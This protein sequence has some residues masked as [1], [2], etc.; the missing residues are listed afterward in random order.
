MAQLRPIFPRAF[1]RAIPTFVPFDESNKKSFR[2]MKSISTALILIVI[3]TSCAYNDVDPNCTTRATVRDLT[4]FDGCGYVFE[5]ED[6]TRLEPLRM[7][8]CGTHPLPKEITEDPLY[9]FEFVHGKKVRISYELAK[10]GVSICMVGPVVK[11]T[12][13]TEEERRNDL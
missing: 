7:F 10:D 2:Q 8:Y 4:G 5:F 13:L 6:G 1:S 12:C 11:I 9:G 3:I